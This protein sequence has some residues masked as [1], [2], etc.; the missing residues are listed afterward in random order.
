MQARQLPFLI[1][2]LLLLLA[3]TCAVVVEA[4]AERAAELVAA[5]GVTEKLT[6]RM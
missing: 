1:A 5:W 3:K 4:A 2:K 6:W